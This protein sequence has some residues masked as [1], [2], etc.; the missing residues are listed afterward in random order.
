[1]FVFSIYV[2]KLPIMVTD[3]SRFDIIMLVL[4]SGVR[5]VN[6]LHSERSLFL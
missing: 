6:V 3:I 5:F 1:M 4:L 2:W